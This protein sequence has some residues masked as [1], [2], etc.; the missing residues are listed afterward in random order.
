MT[1]SA[2]IITTTVDIITVHY[3]DMKTH[4]RKQPLKTWQTCYSDQTDNKLD[5]IK[6]HLRQWTTDTYNRYTELF[7]AKLRIV[8]THATLSYLLAESNASA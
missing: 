3:T 8:H 1:D 2:A 5:V 4:F 7:F 6:L